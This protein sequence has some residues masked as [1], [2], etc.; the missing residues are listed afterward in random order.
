MKALDKFMTR[1]GDVVI[2]MATS[3]QDA[4]EFWPLMGPWFAS[5]E[6]A[7]NIGEG[8]YDHDSLIWTLAMISEKVIGFGAIDL[9]HIGKGDALLNYAFVAA[10]CRHSGTYRRLLEARV[11]LIKED[12]DAR[13]II[14]LCTADSAPTLAKL[15]FTATSKRGRYTR[16]VLEIAR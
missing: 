2:F 16:F 9:S 14:A 7:D 8:L 11:K 5:R 3:K 4:P 13:R 6:V 1:Q 10:H 15:G 12:T